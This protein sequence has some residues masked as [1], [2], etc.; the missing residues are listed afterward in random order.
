M[1]NARLKKL[2]N[3]AT[4]PGTPSLEIRKHNMK[5]AQE[6]QKELLTS[7]LEYTFILNT[8]S[9]GS[10]HFDKR[11]ETITKADA[12]MAESGPLEWIRQGG[13]FGLSKR[14]MN[15]LRKENPLYVLAVQNNWET[16]HG[17]T[18]E[19]LTTLDDI[20]LPDSQDTDVAQSQEVSSNPVKR[21]RKMKHAEL[22]E[23]SVAAARASGAAGATMSTLLPDRLQEGDG[24]H[25]VEQFRRRRLDAR[26]ARFQRE[27]IRCQ[28]ST[29][30][31]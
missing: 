31:K 8:K 4:P 18:P 27:S 9:E 25:P 5:I 10:A 16:R 21:Q 6:R 30:K 26:I 13:M 29:A 20:L 24:L 12:E 19:Q 23:A 7:D 11:T 1:G 22:S 17:C 3:E 14:K 2:K 15:K 28:N